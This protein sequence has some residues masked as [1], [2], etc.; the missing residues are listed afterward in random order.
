MRKMRALVFGLLAFMLSGVPAYADSCD[1]AKNTAGADELVSLWTACLAEHP[2]FSTEAQANV[3]NSRGVAYYEKKDFDHAIGNYDKAVQL[4]PK[5]AKAYNNRG[6]AHEAKGDHAK[7]IADFDH[8]IQLNPKFVVAY[9]AEAWLLATCKDEHFRDGAKAVK[10]A[11]KAVELADDANGH[12]NL[13]AAYAETG[14]FGDAER[15][16]LRA[17]ELTK[18]LGR[19]DPPDS[20]QRLAFYRQKKPYRE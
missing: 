9:N 16:E 8:A 6:N 2:E 7:A 17:I 10:L 4:D 5:S 19:G 1:Q 18:S 13:A 14:N 12:D 3:Y 20:E 11:L 15:E